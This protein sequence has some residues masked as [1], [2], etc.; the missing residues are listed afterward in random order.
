MRVRRLDGIVE[1]DVTQLRAADHP[2]LG[3]DRERVPRL[4]IVDVLLDH[5][6][7]AAGELGQPRG[8]ALGELE[9]QIESVR[10]NVAQQVPG[11]LTALCR[12]PVNT[13]RECRPAGLG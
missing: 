7:A 3:L 11:V 1:L 8:E 2:L 12:G 13:G 6:V 9:A 5:D 4:Q 10:A